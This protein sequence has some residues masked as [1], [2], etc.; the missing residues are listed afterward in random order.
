MWRGTCHH[1]DSDTVRTVDKEIRQ[2]DRKNGWLF[3][4]LVKVRHE[5]YN[6]LVQIRKK[7]FLSDFLET[8]F[9]V[10]HG[11]GT[12]TFDGAE[13]AVA[14]YQ[15]HTLLKF[16]SH[17]N[18]GIVNGAVTVGMILTHGIADDT[19]AFTVWLVVSDSQFIHII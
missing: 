9:S 17:N 16:L 1:A 18:K 2:T 3:L 4:C 7:N 19:G 10:T 6:I 13:I 12:I 5:V 8:G 11:G 15:G 14:V